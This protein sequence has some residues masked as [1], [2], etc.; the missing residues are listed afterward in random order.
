[1]WRKRCEGDGPGGRPRPGETGVNRMFRHERCMGDSARSAARRR[2]WLC[3]AVGGALALTL[4]GCGSSEQ[5]GLEA[6]GGPAATASVTPTAQSETDAILAA[7]R[8]FFARQTEISLAPRAERRTLLEPFTTD[9]ALQRVLGG[10]FAADEMGEVGYGAPIVSPEVRRITGDTAEVVDCQDG[11][12][13]GRKNIETGKI[14][15]RGAKQAKAVVT[16][17][18]GA[19]GS[20]RVATIAFPDEPCAT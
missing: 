6:L 11:R 10:M 20:W 14:T 18:R 3:V 19:D 16:L 8:E 12:E 1:M 7:Y 17:K 5:P 4:A 15:T 9:P 13:A 2:P